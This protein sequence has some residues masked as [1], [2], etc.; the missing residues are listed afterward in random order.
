MSV[1]KHNVRCVSPPVFRS[2]VCEVIGLGHLVLIAH[3]S[4]TSCMLTQD[5]V[6][7]LTR[8]FSVRTWILTLSHFTGVV[9]GVQ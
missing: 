6:S 7:Y 9:H 1:L 2:S 8:F 3:F 5:V 4:R